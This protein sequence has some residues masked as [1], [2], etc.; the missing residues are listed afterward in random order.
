MSLAAEFLRDIQVD[1]RM[2]Y[3]L[4]NVLL[5]FNCGNMYK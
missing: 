5:Y 1:A 2:V 4:E 3:A